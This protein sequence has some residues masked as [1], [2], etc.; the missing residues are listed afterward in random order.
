MFKGCVCIKC[1]KPSKLYVQAVLNSGHDII[2]MINAS[3]FFR[4]SSASCEHKQKVKMG[5]GGEGEGLGE[6]LG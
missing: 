2:H 4:W 5:R 6:R 3:L 1:V